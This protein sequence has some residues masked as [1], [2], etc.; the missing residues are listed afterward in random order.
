MT[1]LQTQK[2]VNFMDN[3]QIVRSPVANSPRSRTSPNCGR[4]RSR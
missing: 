2:I 1:Y 4:K 3:V